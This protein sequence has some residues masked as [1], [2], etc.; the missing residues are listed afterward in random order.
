PGLGVADTSPVRREPAD[1]TSCAAGTTSGP[2]TDD[3]ED[4]W[5]RAAGHPAAGTCQPE[6]DDGSG[7]QRQRNENSF[8]CSPQRVNE[9]RNPLG[10]TASSTASTS[11]TRNTGASTET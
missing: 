10:R 2:R 8:S 4:G 9:S 11:P 7:R 5:R 6:H 1:E 3:R